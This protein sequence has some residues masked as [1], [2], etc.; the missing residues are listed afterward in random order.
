MQQLTELREVL[1]VDRPVVAVEL[2][3]LR[4]DVRVE[5]AV[6]FRDEDRHRV[7]GQDADTPEDHGESQQ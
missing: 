1:Y 6:A 5:V 3:D 7:G 2:L 4:D